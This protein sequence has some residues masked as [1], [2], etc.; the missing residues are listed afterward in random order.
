M[1]LPWADSNSMV[2][3]YIFNVYKLHLFHFNLTIITIEEL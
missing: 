3:L 2:Y 1:D